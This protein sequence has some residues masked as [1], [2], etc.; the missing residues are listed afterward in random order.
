MSMKKRPVIF[1]VPA[2]ALSLAACSDTAANKDETAEPSVSEVTVT[3][4]V[5]T[6]VVS[7]DD[8]ADDRDDHQAAQSQ[9]AASQGELPAEVTGNTGEAEAEMADEGVTAADVERVLA[10]ANNNEAGIEIEWDYDGY[11]E[12]ELGDIDIDINPDGLVLDVDRD[13]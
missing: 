11:W 2:L 8:D 6:E 9:S 10:A 1:A 3:E 5:T 13:D 4:Q 7:G 12:I